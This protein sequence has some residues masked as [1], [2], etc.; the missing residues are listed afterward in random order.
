MEDVV[1]LL[2]QNKFPAAVVDNIEVPSQ[3]FTTVTTGI[4]G[5]VFGDAVAEP[6]ALI[7]PFTVE[8]TV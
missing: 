8:V 2:L 1:A 5:V 6:A 3:L 7:H 4:E